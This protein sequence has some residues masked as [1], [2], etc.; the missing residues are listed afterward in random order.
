MN[1]NAAPIPH[2]RTQVYRLKV[3]TKAYGERVGLDIETWISSAGDF[4]PGGPSGAGKSTL[5]RLLNFLEAAFRRQPLSWKHLIPGSEMPLELRRRVTTVFQRPMLLDRSVWDN[6]AY[7]L[8]LRGQR[9]AHQQVQAPWKKL[10]W[11]TSPGSGRA[12][13]RAARP[14][15][16]PWRGPSSCARGAPA[17]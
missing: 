11:R 14:S 1:D 4:R 3:L 15:A 16:W 9:N 5:L 2:P 17:G 12:P 6:V 7:G 8:R 13:S 10:A